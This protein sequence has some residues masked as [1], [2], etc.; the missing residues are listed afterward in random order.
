[1]SARSGIDA[2][3][4]STAEAGF[5]AASRSVAASMSEPK[6]RFMSGYSSAVAEAVHMASDDRRPLQEELTLVVPR[7][8]Q[9]LVLEPDALELRD[10]DGQV[11]RVGQRIA[12]LP[13]DGLHPLEEEARVEAARDARLDVAVQTDGGLGLE[14]RHHIG[15]D[16]PR[17]VVEQ[18]L[19]AP[20]EAAVA[21]LAQRDV[22]IG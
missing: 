9:V 19:G 22:P 13:V 10:P 21:R 1:M 2:T 20:H 8:V 17:F 6:T 15:A 7:C 14:V 12:R 18:H 3:T 11:R 4:L 5:C 16:I